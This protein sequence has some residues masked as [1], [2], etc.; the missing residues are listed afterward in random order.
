VR[1]SA[2]LCDA[3]S[4]TSGERKPQ[5]HASLWR[6]AALVGVA[7]FL[8]GCSVS[9]PIGSLFGDDETE[10]KATTGAVNGQPYAAALAPALTGKAAL[11]PKMD[12]EDAR[13][14]Q[15]A[16]ALALDPEG[17][18]VPVNWDNPQSGSKGSFRSVGDY[19]LVGNQL[20]RRFAADFTMTSAASAYDGQACRSGPQS[21]VIVEANAQGDVS[22]IAA[23]GDTAIAPTDETG[24]PPQR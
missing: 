1:D 12:A 2:A 7:A 5:A 17:K 14:S 10:K 11:S 6:F 21:W 4:A 23:P 9:M 3:D 24:A 20:C 13:R 19:F 16:L 8:G 15:S 18:G 22:Q